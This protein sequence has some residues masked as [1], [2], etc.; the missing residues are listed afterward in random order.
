MKNLRSFFADSFRLIFKGGA[1]FYAW[2]T[3][4]TLIALHG[5]YWYLQQVQNGLQITGMTDHVSWGL[6]ISNFTFFVG[7]AAAAVMLVIPLYVFGDKNFKNA[8]LIG[9]GVAVSALVMCLLYVTVDVGRPDRLWHL[10]PGLGFF[11][12]PRSMLAWDVMVLNGYLLLNLL[13]PF[14][15]L[16]SKYCQRE[17]NHKVYVPF[18]FLSVIWAISIH[19]VTAFL[20]A[21][22]S[23][24]PYWNSSILGP[25]FLA[26]AFSAGPAFIAL[27]LGFIRR[28]TRYEIAEEVF[29]KLG[30]IM[31]VAA[32][33]NLFLLGCEIFKEFYTNDHHSLSAKY[34]F[35]GLGEHRALVPWIWSSI[36]LNL[37]AT[38]TL[39]IHR[40][41]ATRPIFYAACVVL[42]VAIWIEKGLG[43]IIPGFIPSPQGEIVEYVPTYPEIS[44][45]IGIF[46]IGLIVMTCLVRVAI[47]I[48]NGELHRRSV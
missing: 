18:V 27:I 37:L 35:F 19:T 12:W 42:I 17:P 2:M 21:G 20:Y 8:V 43:L 3:I 22:L 30:I 46:A 6:Y 32:Q 5:F 47:P 39:T 38:A 36:G 48:M 23:S 16:Y 40:L 24:K 4:L 45:T 31:T 9:E 1:V 28:Y 13:I 10:I 29:S 34:L 7:I 41:R 11:N 33:I 15:I 44:I 26:S 14:Y 25:R